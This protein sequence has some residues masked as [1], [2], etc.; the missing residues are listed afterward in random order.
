MYDKKILEKNT[1]SPF[2]M[3]YRLHSTIRVMR[4]YIHIIIVNITYITYNL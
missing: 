1:E 4:Q 3:V 2:R